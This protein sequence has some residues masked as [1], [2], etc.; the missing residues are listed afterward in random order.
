[1][2]TWLSGVA[3]FSVGTVTPGQF[4]PEISVLKSSGA[5]TELFSVKSNI[6]FLCR[7]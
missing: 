6:A 5:V 2:V 3:W 1:M 7:I 4:L